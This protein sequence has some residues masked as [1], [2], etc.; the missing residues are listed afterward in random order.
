[1]RKNTFGEVHQKDRK[2]Y[3]FLR[4]KDLNMDFGARDEKLNNYLFTR[5]GSVF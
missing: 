1:M 5:R 2:L 4:L 3:T